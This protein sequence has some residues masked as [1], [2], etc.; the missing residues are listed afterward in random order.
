MINKLT[1]KSLAIAIMI[2][3]AVTNCMCAHARPPGKQD[4]NN[5]PETGPREGPKPKPLTYAPMRIEADF[6]G[7]ETSLERIKI[8]HMAIAADDEYENL[9]KVTITVNDELAGFLFADGWEGESE[10]E[11]RIGPGD[12]SQ[13]VRARGAWNAFPQ[14]N[15]LKLIFTK[16]GLTKVD[17]VGF[18]GFLHLKY[19]PES[20]DEE[21][22][23]EPDDQASED[24]AEKEE[25]N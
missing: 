9:V 13:W 17:P 16:E 19:D 18:K 22:H 25:S 23:D 14:S 20:L 2:L 5:K 1:L 15:I 12:I 4:G 3:I 11:L 24:A 8:T 21:T 10:E 7:W 6:N